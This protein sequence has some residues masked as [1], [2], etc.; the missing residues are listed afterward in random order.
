MADKRKT[1][2]RKNLAQDN[3]GRSLVKKVAKAVI[4]S[5]SVFFL[6]TLVFAFVLTKTEVPETLQSILPFCACAASGLVGGI[7]T[8]KNIG[9]KTLLFCLASS[10]IQSFAVGVILLLTVGNVGIKT[11]LAFAVT[12]LAYSAGAF[13][14]MN[15]KPKRKV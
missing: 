1:K 8:A 5:T 4:T 12:F 3:S 6:L 7:I 10:A 11:L 2:G 14:T 13:W 9:A 15:R